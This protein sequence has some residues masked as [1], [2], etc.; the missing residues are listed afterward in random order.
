MS[1]SLLFSVDMVQGKAGM[2]RQSDHRFP[3]MV[4]ESVRFML[5]IPVGVQQS[6]R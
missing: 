1:H 3:L 2:A 4:T 6:S 5:S